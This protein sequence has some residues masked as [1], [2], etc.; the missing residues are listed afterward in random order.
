MPARWARAISASAALRGPGTAPAPQPDEPASGRLMARSLVGREKPA[1]PLALVRPIMQPGARHRRLQRAKGGDQPTRPWRCPLAAS[2]RSQR[3]RPSAASSS[4]RGSSSMRPRTCG[5]AASSRGSSHSLPA[6][7]DGDA[8]AAD[9]ASV[10][11]WVPSRSRQPQPTPPRP[12]P[13][14]PATRPGCVVWWIIRVLRTH[15]ICALR[16]YAA[17]EGNDLAD[18]STRCRLED[19][20][21]NR[22]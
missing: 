6:K 9:I 8:G 12:I 3:P 11:A 10:T 15:S 20:L 19:Q 1:P 13:T 16:S 5:R 18:V 17:I 4:S 2:P 22:D 14:N 7:G 21:A